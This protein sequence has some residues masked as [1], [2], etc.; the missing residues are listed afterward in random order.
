MAEY[1]KHQAFTYTH[2]ERQKEIVTQCV[3]SNIYDTSVEPYLVEKAL[4]DTGATV[5][6]VSMRIVKYLQLKPVRRSVNVVGVHG[7]ARVHF[8]PVVII[9]P[10]DVRRVWQ[11][12]LGLD[13]GDNVDVII[14][15]DIIGTGD[16]S[17]SDGKTISYRYPPLTS[18]PTDFVRN[19]T[20]DS[21]R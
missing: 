8:Y 17:V 20:P 14:G 2:R 3:V 9:L 7:S 1:L 10:K 11:M 6:A 12:A 13:T 21:Q 5:T 15:M 16:F 4:W 18:N 19:G